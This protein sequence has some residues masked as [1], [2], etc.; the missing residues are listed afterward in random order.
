[1]ATWGWLMIGVPTNEPKPPGFVMVNVPSLHFVGGEL[2][3][4]RALAEVVD[5]ARHAE[6][7]ELVGPLDDR[8]DEAPVE[9]HGDADVDVAPED[10][11]VAHDGGS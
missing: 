6:E 4:P 5:G 7:G 2:L 11:G 10:G 8:D 1:M 9:R 3:G